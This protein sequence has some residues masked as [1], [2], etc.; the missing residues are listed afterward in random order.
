MEFDI[1]SDAVHVPRDIREG[2]LVAYLDA[3]A[4]DASMAYSFGK[5][6]ASALP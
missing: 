5:G 4:Y 3:G 2:A 1:L 6:G